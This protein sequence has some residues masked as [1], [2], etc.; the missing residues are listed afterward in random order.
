MEKKTV[1]DQVEVKRD[2]TLQIRFRKVLVEDDGSITDLGY[3]RAV[4]M[5]GDDLAAT[6][7]HVGNHL[8]AMNNGG[9][10]AEEK[11]FITEVK[12]AMWTQERVKAKQPK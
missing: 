3:H 11:A 1:V 10:S 4:A 6:L 9:L 12:D 7:D 2:G 8:S 5:P